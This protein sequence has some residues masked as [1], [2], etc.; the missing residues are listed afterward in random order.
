MSHFIDYMKVLGTS[1][2]TLLGGYAVAWKSYF[3]SSGSL[4][5]VYKPLEILEIISGNPQGQIIF[6][7]ILGL[8]SHILFC[9]HFH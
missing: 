7:P 9:S 4:S 8:F 1:P 3:H 5:V 2:D 6:L